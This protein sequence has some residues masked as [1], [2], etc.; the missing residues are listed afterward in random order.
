MVLCTCH[1]NYLRIYWM[2]IKY[3]GSL[4]WSRLNE[5]NFSKETCFDEFFHLQSEPPRTERVGDEIFNMNGVLTCN[6][7]D[8]YLNT[9]FKGVKKP[10]LKTVVEIINF[11]VATFEN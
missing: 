8:R 7:F 1:R 2:S 4:V 6:L 11:E 9:L 3:A 5:V 10:K